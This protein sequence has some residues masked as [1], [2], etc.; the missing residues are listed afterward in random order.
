MKGFFIVLILGLSSLTSIGQNSIS[1]HVE[2]ANGESL[3]QASVFLM[4]TYHAA[5]SDDSGNYIIEDIPDGNYTL[6]ASYVGYKSYSFDIELAG[7]L[8]Q[9]IDL[10]ESLLS[11]EGVQINS[12]RVK[13]GGAFA[14]T[15]I[16][17]E[18]LDDENLGQDIPFLLRWTPSAVVTSDAGTGIGYT[19]IRIR[20]TDATSINVTING[21]PLNDSESHGVFWVDLPDFMS[22]V[23]NLQI[24]RGVG[25][26][27]NGSSAFGGT[28]SLNTNKLYQNPYVH[29]NSSFGSFNSRKLSVSLGTGLL[30]DKYSIDG[31]YSVVKSDGYIDRASSDLK[32][33]YFSAARMGDKSSLRLI[34]FSGHERTYQA[35]NGT[36]ESRVN[37]DLAEL[38]NHFDRNPWLYTQSADST[39]LF[40]SDRKY[41]YYQYPNQVD[42]YQQD[43]YQL[44]YSLFP[45]SKFQVKASLH[46]TRGHGFF[47]EFKPSEGYGKY[48]LPIEIEVNGDTITSGNL[49]RRRWL[50]ND[51]YGVV[52]N[53]EY[54]PN[55]ALNFQVGGA[56]SQYKGDHF[57]VVLSAEGIPNVNMA[58]LYYD[59]IGDKTDANAYI[60]ANY[61]VGKFN[62]FGDA[63]MRS[64]NYKIDGVSNDLDNL[65]LDLNYSFFNPKFGITYFLKDNHNI[66]ASIAIANKEPIRGDII[67]N[68][69]EIPLHETLMDIEVGYRLKNDKF[70]FEWN[71]YVMLYDNQLVPTGE[72]NNSGAFLKKNV[73]KSSRIGTE[74]SFSSEILDRLYWNVNTT[75]SSN[76]VESYNEVFE[77]ADTVFVYENTDIS[78]SPSIIASNSFMY[79]LE[80][81]LEF[82]LSTKYVGKQFL[83][84][85]S[86]INRSLPGYTYSNLRIGYNWDPSFLGKVKLNAMI[87]NLLDTKYSSNGY[88]YSSYSRDNDQVTTENFLYPQAGIHVMLGLNVEF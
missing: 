79:K 69:D 17:R 68:L 44:H 75:I 21:V 8:K 40:G 13:D 59:N 56:I 28:I 50:D 35:W 41:N 85:T 67:E 76:K 65:D 24:Q 78:Y 10:G 61:K 4:G 26:S 88:T 37:G 5:I 3:I 29:A 63:Q 57:G 39:N 25:T 15:N 72:V 45:S 42:D 7:D 36:P 31:R 54:K 6:K 48:D 9:N 81:G 66:Y 46:Y 23:D 34:A 27:T 2:N 14:Y 11:L 73:G 12:T 16:D 43:H 53:S 22:S 77:F 52:L 19:G 49:I 82:E 55:S 20:G 51:F 1:G 71:N 74:L 60:K 47:E 38:Q 33:W 32:S 64:I 83:D 80:R 70:V 87:Y 58:N 18:D 84:N 62:F 30:N 86:N